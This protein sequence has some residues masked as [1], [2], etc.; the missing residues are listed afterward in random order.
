[1]R[2]AATDRDSVDRSLSSSARSTALVMII[3]AVSRIL[4]FVR[5]AAV[6]AVFGATGTADVLNA[7]FNIPNNLRKLLAEGALSS[8]FIPVLSQAGADP[9]AVATDAPRR[10]VRNLLAFQYAV[11]VPLLVL[12]V[13]FAGPITRFILDFDAPEYQDLAAELFRWF[14][15][16]TLLISVS[17]ILMGTLNSRSSFTIPAITPILFSIC[18]IGSILF[19]SPS[20]GVHSMSVGVLA[21]GVAQI[22]FQAP[23]FKRLGFDF[24]PDFDFGNPYFRRIMRR[25]F[26]VVAASS[27]FAV[28]QFVSIYFATGLETGSSSALAYAVVFWQ[29]PQGI[30]GVSIMTV[31]FPRMSREAALEDRTALKRTLGF[32]IRGIVALIVPSAIVLGLM[33]NELVAVAFQ[34][35]EFGL[36]D[37]LLTSEVLVGYCLGMASVVAFSFLQRFFYSTG[38]YRTPTVTAIG[39]VVVDVAL[40]LWLK[41]TPLRVTGLA[42]ANSVSF[43]LGA[44]VLLVGARR[45]LGGIDLGAIGLTL[46]K[47]LAATAPAAGLILAARRWITGW[48]QDGSSLAGFGIVAAIG[49]ATLALIAGGFVLLRVEVVSLL[50]K[51]RRHESKDRE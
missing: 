50:V 42:L 44:I 6:A 10:I 1:M 47:T 25:W 17:A 18:V 48:W 34:R 39:V 43:T 28:N 16:Y 29:L 4:G 38:D 33:A 24:R 2:A 32:G 46:A 45:V 12:A 36:V 8:A 37:T 11:L 23:R 21:G 3:T 27:V 49:I 40:S 15:H 31:L 41:E 30:L 20:L 13:I 22:V 14:I 5:Q 26:P 9:E 35:G 7:V 19:G 51:R